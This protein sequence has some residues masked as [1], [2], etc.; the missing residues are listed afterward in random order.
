MDEEQ[1]KMCNDAASLM[2]RNKI[3]SNTEFFQI[4]RKLKRNA[5]KWHV[6]DGDLY[7]ISELDD[8]W[9]E[10]LDEKK[11]RTIERMF[12]IGRMQNEGMASIEIASQLGISNQSVNRY[13]SELKA[14]IMYPAIVRMA[15]DFVGWMPI[16]RINEHLNN[17]W[18]WSWKPSPED[19]EKAVKWTFKASDSELIVIPSIGQNVLENLRRFQELWEKR[20]AE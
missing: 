9:V 6:Y 11:R 3:L 12:E 17:G 8:W 19:L 2:W 13:S 10:E 16:A 1:F 7:K 20:D 18:D 14:R 15:M 4:S 5:H